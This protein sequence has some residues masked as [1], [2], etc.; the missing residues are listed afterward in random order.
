MYALARPGSNCKTQ[1]SPLVRQGASHQET[2]NYLRVI[3]IWPCVTDG[4]HLERPADWLSVVTWLTICSERV[5]KRWIKRSPVPG[6]KAGNPRWR[7]RRW[8]AHCWKRCVATQGGIGARICI[9][10]VWE[11]RYWVLNWSPAAKQYTL[12]AVDRR[13]N[14]WAV[15]T[16]WI[17]LIRWCNQAGVLRYAKESENLSRGKRSLKKL[18]QWKPLSEQEELLRAVEICSVYKVTNVLSLIVIKYLSQ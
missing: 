12:E 7:C 15:R 13:Y 8:N 5:L 9:Q 18:W 16:F 17:V 1:T 10:W 11:R 4:W 3:Q 14:S 2:L 6:T